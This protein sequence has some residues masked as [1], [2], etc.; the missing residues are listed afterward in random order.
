MCIRDRLIEER[1]AKRAAEADTTATAKLGSAGEPAAP[2]AKPADAAAPARFDVG[3]IAAL[4]V[5]IGGIGAFGTAVLAALFGLGWWMP[6]GVLGVML[7]IS[8]PSML[9]AY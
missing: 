4:G 5:A 3:T 8:G 1:V 9:L 7:A 2:E 6:F